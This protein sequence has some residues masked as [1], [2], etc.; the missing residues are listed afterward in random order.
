MAAKV[1]LKE[2]AQEVGLSPSAVSLV[3]N[4][5][6]CRISEENRKRIKEVAA[7]KRMYGFV[8]L[9]DGDWEAETPDD[10]DVI[11]RAAELS[12]VMATGI[13]CIT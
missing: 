4:D 5:R 2:I 7:R 9:A 3:L 11:D 6:P 13:R 8:Y 1:T 10:F 12:R